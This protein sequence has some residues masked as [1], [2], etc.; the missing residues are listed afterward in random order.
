MVFAKSFRQRRILPRHFIACISTACGY[1]A[2]T[3]CQ[4]L[5]TKTTAPSRQ[6]LRLFKREAL[7]THASL[8]CS[9]RAFPS[10]VKRD[11][12]TP[13]IS[14]HPSHCDTCG[15]RAQKFSDLKNKMSNDVGTIMPVAHTQLAVPSLCHTSLSFAC[16]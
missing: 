12:S 2:A 15:R 13:V 3:L 14:K 10:L 1:A 11:K 8:L 9:H 7:L 4:C 6:K 16:L 5:T